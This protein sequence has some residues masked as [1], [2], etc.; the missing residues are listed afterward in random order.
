MVD[1]WLGTPTPRMCLKLASR[2]GNDADAIGSVPAGTVTKITMIKHS[3]GVDTAFYLIY[4]KV[5]GYEKDLIVYDGYF[6]ELRDGVRPN[7]KP[8]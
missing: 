3:N 4:L 5:P 6:A 2:M 7:R 1:M 8:R